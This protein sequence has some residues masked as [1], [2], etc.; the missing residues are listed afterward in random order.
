MNTSKFKDQMRPNFT[1][2][3]LIA[4]AALACFT[5]LP[6]IAQ[7]PGSLDASFDGDG[8]AINPIVSEDNANA[9]ARQA[10][11]KLVIA[12]WAI[13][14]SGVGFGVVRMNPDGSLDPTFNGNGR[15]I[16]AVEGRFSRAS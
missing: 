7:I 5:V 8:K 3:L 10:D 16:T 13:K 9:I 14:K 2:N 6:V 4:I 1:L 11:G 15:V 12:G